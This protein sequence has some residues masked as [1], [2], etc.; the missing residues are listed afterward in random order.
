MFRFNWNN[1]IVFLYNNWFFIYFIEYKI[2]IFFKKIL[3]LILFIIKVKV[4]CRIIVMYSNF[5]SKKK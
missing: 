5:W 2:F 3:V 1:I 4:L